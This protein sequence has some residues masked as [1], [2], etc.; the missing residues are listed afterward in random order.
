MTRTAGASHLDG[1]SYQLALVG[2]LHEECG[3]C[4]LAH[5]HHQAALAAGNVMNPVYS[6]TETLTAGER[7]QR[8]FPALPGSRPSADLGKDGPPSDAPFTLLRTWEMTRPTPRCGV[9]VNLM[10]SGMVAGSLWVLKMCL[11]SLGATPH[12]AKPPGGRCGQD[13]ERLGRPL[14]VRNKIWAL[15][16]DK[17]GP[18]SCRPQPVG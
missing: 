16:R 8:L 7:A 4:A 10:L 13:R 2:L 15:G 1:H 3:G 5:G 17:S 9:N 6:G 12:L 11:L 14:R 18:Q